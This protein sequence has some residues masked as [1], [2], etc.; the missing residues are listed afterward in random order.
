MNPYIVARLYW[1]RHSGMEMLEHD[2]LRGWL[3]YEL[4]RTGA[5][6]PEA[7]RDAESCSWV[8]TG[9]KLCGLT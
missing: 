8:N 7:R 4:R 1:R 5:R 2:G 3:P 6:R 9:R